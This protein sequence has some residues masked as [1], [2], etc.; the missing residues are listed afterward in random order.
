MA[1]SDNR[2]AKVGMLQLQHSPRQ[3]LDGRSRG[4]LHEQVTLFA[5]LKGIKH[6]VYGIAER[7]HKTGHIGIRDC[8]RLSLVD[9]VAEQ[10]N[11]RAA[12]GHDVAVPSQTQNRIPRQHLPRAG[13]HILLHDSLRH[14]HSVDGIGRLVRGQEDGLLHMVGYTGGNH[15]VGTGYIGF[16]RF[17]RIELAGGHLLQS[18]GM[19]Y[20]VHTAERIQ[21]GIVIPHISYVELDFLRV[22]RIQLLIG[23]PHIILLLLIP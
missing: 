15:I 7:H 18:C 17:H 2:R 23:M 3:R 21:N 9:P 22:L 8:Q 20:I 14:A 1:R 11:N 5:M 19:K 12:G 10:R 13:N 4:L 16:D 6:K